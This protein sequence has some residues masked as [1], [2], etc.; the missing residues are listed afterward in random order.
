M[1]VGEGDL[2]HAM[3]FDRVPTAEY[4]RGSQVNDQIIDQLR[5]MSAE[6]L[7]GSEDFQK[8][9]EKI[10]RYKERKNRKSV[11]VNKQKFEEELADLNKEKEERELFEDLAET[12]EEE[13]VK[14]DFYFDEALAITV[15]FLRLM[16]VAQAN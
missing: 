12:N 9:V 4:H 8:L 5:R 7:K 6:R 10:E 3:Q 1:D 14:R 15:D 13:V 2:D 16:D 11:T